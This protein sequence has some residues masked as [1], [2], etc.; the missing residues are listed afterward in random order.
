[1]VLLAVARLLSVTLAA[2][3]YE[4]MRLTAPVS[5]FVSSAYTSRLPKP[6]T[7][8]QSNLMASPALAA[9]VLLVTLPP[10]TV[11][12]SVLPSDGGHTLGGCT[13]PEAEVVMRMA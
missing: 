13:T 9:K 3:V 2:P 7:T 8:C 5:V 11:T 4:K 10:C 12:L 1:M 6:P